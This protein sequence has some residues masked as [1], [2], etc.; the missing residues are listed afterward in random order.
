[1]VCL[2]SLQKTKLA[3]SRHGEYIGEVLEDLQAENKALRKQIRDLK[4]QLA[5][6]KGGA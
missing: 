4:K 5:A 2:A 1:M 3:L 6:L